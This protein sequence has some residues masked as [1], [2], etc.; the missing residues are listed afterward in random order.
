MK[1]LFTY[2]L[3]LLSTF[4][5]TAQTA[6]IS[7]KV[8]DI[9]GNFLSGVHVQ[10][11][12]Q[13]GAVVATATDVNVYNFDNLSTGQDY[14]I[15]FSK[16][17]S[18]LNG[19]STFDLVLMHKHILGTGDLTNPYQIIAGDVNGSNSISVADIVE[20]RLLILGVIES[21]RNGQN[22]GF[23]PAA[24]PFQNPASPFAELG[25]LSNTITLTEDV[26]NLNYYAIKYGDLNSSVV[27]E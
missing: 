15:Q 25:N 16:G 8:T 13:T 3:V 19:L 17:G 21:F 5:L 2:V 18:T 26:T 10:L 6:S 4:A 14:T 27:I 20:M 1:T 7:G 22:W 24:Y 23:L 9:E 12:D 11:L